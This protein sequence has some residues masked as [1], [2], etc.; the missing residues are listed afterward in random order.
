[1]NEQLKLLQNADFDIFHFLPG[2]K[3]NQVF[4]QGSKF[5]EIGEK[6]D[7]SSLGDCYHILLFRIGENENGEICKLEKNEA[8]L[9]SPL[10]YMSMLIPQEFY[11]IIC[12]KTTSSDK[13]VTKVFD[14][15]QK[16]C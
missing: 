10:E 5:K 7:G 2:E 1:M 3:K 6:V 11:G 12:K 15:L 16:F 4:I 14:L 8:I 13:F 9:I